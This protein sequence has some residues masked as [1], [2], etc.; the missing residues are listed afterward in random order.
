MRL[1]SFEFR[2]LGVNLVNESRIYEAAQAI[3]PQAGVHIRTGTLE[4]R[5]TVW[6]TTD[7][8]AAYLMVEAEDPSSALF[9]ALD[10]DGCVVASARRRD[11]G[12]FD[13][14]HDIPSAATV[15]PES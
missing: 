4:G 6:L 9:H 7:R 5:P 15:G 3:A 8:G 1:W 13:V 12:A 2:K 14:F 11:D 10:G